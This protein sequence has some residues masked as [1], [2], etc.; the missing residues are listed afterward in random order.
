MTSMNGLK[1]IMPLSGQLRSK[2][3]ARLYPVTL[4]GR[5]P[6]NHMIPNSQNQAPLAKQS[7]SP[8]YRKWGRPDPHGLQCKSKSNRIPHAFRLGPRTK[9]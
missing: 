9:P 5:G 4:V 3:G 6:P 1:S 7:S 8:M 2:N